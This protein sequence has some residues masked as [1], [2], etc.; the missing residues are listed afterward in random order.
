MR[1]LDWGR[2]IVLAIAFLLLIAGVAAFF[3]FMAAR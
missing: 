3:I 2:I 1:D